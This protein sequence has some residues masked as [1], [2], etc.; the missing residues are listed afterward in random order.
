M[1]VG[2]G[3]RNRL[4]D[5][6][7]GFDVSAMLSV[8]RYQLY[9][10]RVGL[11]DRRTT[12]LELKPADGGI[13]S[14]ANDL[15]SRSPGLAAYA[16]LRYRDYTRHRFYGIG[17]DTTEAGSSAYRWRGLSS[18]AVLQWQLSRT[19]GLAARA[20]WLES[21]IGVRLGGSERPVDQ[22]FP[23]GDLPGYE[24]EPRYVAVGAAAAFDH[25]D[26]PHT[27]SRG[28]FVGAAAWRFE[29][30]GT[31]FDFTRLTVDTRGFVQPNG[32]GGTLAV[33]A[34]LSSD[35][36]AAGAQVPFFLMQALGGGETLRGYSGQRWRD[37]AVAHG[38]LEYRL[39]LQSW[40]EVAPFMDAGTVAPA[41]SRLD[42][43][44]TLL[45]AG[46]GARVLWDHAVIGRLDW[47]WS[48]SG[49]RLTISTGPAF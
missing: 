45:S 17:R 38:S 42:F 10:L 18:D 41:V 33:R 5:S 35:R 13:G 1:A 47:A 27:P 34:V 37:R 4:F 49:Q 12:T 26:R 2:V 36:A 11:I 22:L 30:A 39:R 8:R 16:D 9:R 44:R 46:L 14:F 40:L 3:Y 48:E 7:V 19:V 25:R 6:P 29:A 21:R 32:A 23:L 15:Q 28:W 43:R 24:R 20:S 31:R